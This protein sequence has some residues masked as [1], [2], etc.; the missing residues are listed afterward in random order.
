MDLR[1]LRYFLAVAEGGARTASAAGPQA[2]ADGR[3]AE[4]PAG[5]GQPSCVHGLCMPDRAHSVRLA[6]L[7]MPRVC[8][9]HASM[10]IRWRSTWGNITMRHPRH[11]IDAF[12]IPGIVFT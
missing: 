10:I 11:R 5:A 4:I 7:L 9:G 2:R 6:V 12:R 8:S 1:Q 3:G